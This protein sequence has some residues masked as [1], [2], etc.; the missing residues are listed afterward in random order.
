M[1]E[2]SLRAAAEA[3]G[4][5]HLFAGWEGMSGEQRVELIADLQNVDLG[6][7]NAIHTASMAADGAPVACDAQPYRGVLRLEDGVGEERKDWRAHGLELIAQ[8]K[9]AVLLLAGGQGTRLGS[10]APKGCYD[11]GLPSGYS[12][13]QLQ[14]ARL[15]KVQALASPDGQSKPLQWY[16]MTSRFTHAATLEHF[17]AGDFFGLD[18]AQV[19]FFQQGFLPCLTVEGK[20]IMESD[21]RLA[22]APDGNGGVYMALHR[23]GCLAHMVSSGVECVDVYCVDNILARVGDPLFLGYCHSRGAEVG[24]KAVAKAHPEEKVGVFAS[25]GGAL[26][27]LEYSELDPAVASASDPEST[28]GALLY[29][30]SNICMHYFSVAWLSRV[31]QSLA[32]GAAYHVARKNIPSKDGPVSGIKLEL[33]IFDTFGM[34]APGAVALMEVERKAEFAPVKNAPGSATDSPDTA[35]AALLSLHTSWVEA[36]GGHVMARDGVEVAPSVSYAGEGLTALCKGGV[37]YGGPRSEILLGLRPPP[38]ID[39]TAIQTADE[40]RREGAVVP[41]SE[42]RPPA[43]HYAKIQTADENR[44]KE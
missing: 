14:A 6:Y 15:K 4:Q 3:A 5:G 41:A 30:W 21:S 25:R 31:A 9:A 11:V 37:H 22:K 32:A 33:F 27:V 20:V 8:G 34:A 1:D 12:L 36:A 35:R 28:S 10:S 29:N 40:Y 13:F 19:H 18:R 24:S 26:A 2:A 39:Y 7:V 23:S 43:M 16:I 42:S 44:R 38:A 17:E